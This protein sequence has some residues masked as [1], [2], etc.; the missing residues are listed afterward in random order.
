MKSKGEYYHIACLNLIEQDD[1]AEEELYTK[2]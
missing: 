2:P 1:A